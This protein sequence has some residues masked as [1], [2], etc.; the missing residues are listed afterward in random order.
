MGMFSRK[1]GICMK[2]KCYIR[3]LR[4]KH[5]IK[6]FLL[7][8]PI[9]FG[10]ALLDIE[11]MA[12]GAIAFLVFS[13]M[14][15]VVY[16]IND[17]KDLEKDKLHEKKKHRPIASGMINIKEAQ[18]AALMLFVLCV[19]IKLLCFGRTI[20]TWT[21]LIGYLLVNMAYSVWGCKKVPLLDV[22]LLVLGFVFR[23]YYGAIISGFE[24][25]QWLYLVIVSGAFYM[26]FGKRRNE[27]IKNND[28][29]REVLRYYNQAFLDKSMYSCMTLAIMFYSLWCLE[30]YRGEI[31][32]YLITIPILMIILFKYSLNVES[33]MKDGDPIE[34]ILS[35]RILILLV[36][37]FCGMLGYFLYV[38]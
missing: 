10:G 2:I 29:T 20:S 14:S 17:I 11:I 28:S 8:L 1:W 23:V 22:V 24:V 26:G 18:I 33:Q 16:I 25:S 30:Q 13:F 5:Y 37:F 9:V 19:V 6:N 35:D 36:L 15:S 32:N 7:F 34:V 3:M 21:V 38:G 31:K 4:V 12:R 27:L